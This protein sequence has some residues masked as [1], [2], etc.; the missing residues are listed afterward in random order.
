MITSRKNYTYSSSSPKSIS[1]D[2]DNTSESGGSII[3]QPEIIEPIITPS[4]PSSNGSNSQTSSQGQSNDILNNTPDDNTSAGSISNNPSSSS[5]TTSNN[6]SSTTNNN[7]STNPNAI[8]SATTE[9]T[10]NYIGG[11][12]SPNSPINVKKPKP[13]YLTYG[14][15]GVIG[16]AIVYKLFFTK[17]NPS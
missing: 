6:N 16:L 1:T 8:P 10:K 13:N 15:I 12:T 4:N 9:Q 5:A 14:I 11:G 17:N 7:N 3:V 2:I